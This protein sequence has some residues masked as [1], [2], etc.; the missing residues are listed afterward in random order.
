MLGDSALNIFDL[1]GAFMEKKVIVYCDDQKR[2]I[3]EFIQ[4]HGS[5]FDILP[6]ADTRDLLKSIEQL[7]KPPSLVLLD[8]YHPREDDANYAE[9]ATLAEESL[10]KLDAQIEETNKAVLNAWEP[11]GLEI[12]K[13]IRQKYPQEKLPIAIYTQKGLMLLGDNEMREAELNGADWL[14]KKKLSARTEE[15]AINRIIMRTP[16][17]ITNKSV[18]NYRWGLAFSWLLIGLLASRLIFN[19]NQFTDISVAAVIGILTALITYLISPIL[20][21]LGEKD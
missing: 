20:A 13:L 1:K 16:E 9:K 15:I 18:K 19:T 4:R 2:F 5:Y 12:L 3:D 21:K 11:T 14:I 8:L 7:K 10:A 6:V 17:R